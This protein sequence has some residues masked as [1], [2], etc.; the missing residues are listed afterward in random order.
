MEKTVM[1]N[2]N[3][4]F[5]E[6]NPTTRDTYSCSLTQMCVMKVLWKNDR[7]LTI[8]KDPTDQKFRIYGHWT[9]LKLCFG[10]GYSILEVAKEN[11]A[12]EIDII[13]K[14]L[15]TKFCRPKV[16][17]AKPPKVPTEVEP[18]KRKRRSDHGTKVPSSKTYSGCAE[19]D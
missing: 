7:C 9:R 4:A 15:R 16:Q 8:V 10:E 6:I 14:F 5:E 18:R 17:V 11:A 2:P 13:E 19:E 1:T 12:I 3:L